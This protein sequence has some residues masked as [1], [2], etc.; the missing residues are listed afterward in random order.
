MRSLPHIYRLLCHSEMVITTIEF[1][2]ASIV[3]GIEIPRVRKFCRNGQW[4]I[5]NV[6]YPLFVRISVTNSNWV[7]LFAI[8]H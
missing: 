1:K 7:D 2:R 4:V 5:D 8:Y 3:E 6:L